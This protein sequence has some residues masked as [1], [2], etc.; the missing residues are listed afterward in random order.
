V[1]EIAKNIALLQREC[2]IKES[3][4]RFCDQIKFGLMEVVYE[5]A[6]GM[7]VKYIFKMSKLV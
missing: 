4:D 5:W 7:V 6:N 3:I 1:D 2:G